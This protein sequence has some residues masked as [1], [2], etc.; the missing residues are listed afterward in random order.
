MNY[1]VPSKGDQVNTHRRFY[2]KGIATVILMLLYGLLSFV[3]GQQTVFNVPTTDV[4]DKGKVYFEL[5]ISAKP[6]NST[7]LDKFSSF[8]PRVVLGAGGRIEVGL[9]IL[10]NVQPGPDSTTL[11]PAIKWKVY[12]GKDNGWAIAI[13]G[14]L[15]FPVRNKSYNAGAYAYTIA[16]KTFNKSTR[17]GFGSY[18][19]SKNVV[20]PNAN[21]AGGQF[22]FEQPVTKKLNFN[23]DW[24]TGKHANGY[25]TTG[26]AYKL[27]NK[28]TGVAAYS[29]G[30][31]NAS[32]G[33]HFFY[34]EL[35]YNFN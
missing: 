7:T 17:L 1:S 28:L 15:Y 30:N 8:V 26:A 32:K 5:D 10:G 2:T 29:I 19:F 25:F 6:N 31:A 9:N 21:R 4:L 22:T 27:T 3:H 16:Q 14:N 24:F 35:G 33:N 13:G 20:A 12:D 23:A 18:F 34:F 11:A